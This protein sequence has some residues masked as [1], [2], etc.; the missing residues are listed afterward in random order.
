[1]LFNRDSIISPH[2]NNPSQRIGYRTTAMALSFLI[3]FKQARNKTEMLNQTSDYE[4]SKWI[5][6]TNHAMC[7]IVELQ[8]DQSTEGSDYRSGRRRRGWRWCRE[9]SG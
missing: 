6:L 5:Y 3:S 2:H 9:S 8:Y 7:R 1:L 4:N